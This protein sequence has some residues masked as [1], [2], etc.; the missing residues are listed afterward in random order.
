MVPRLDES[1]EKRRA[2]RVGHGA[3]WLTPLL[4]QCGWAV[5]RSRGTYLQAQFFRLRARQ[6]PKKAVIAIAPSILTAVYHM[7]KNHVP[8]HELGSDHS[9]KR[10]PARIATKLA[11]RIKDLGDDVQYSVAA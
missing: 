6:G 7:L 4:T 10:D 2:T 1:A 5:L 11:Q 8:Y 9:V 3:P